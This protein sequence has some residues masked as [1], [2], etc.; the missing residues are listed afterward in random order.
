MLLSCTVASHIGCE[1]T[2]I[3]SQSAHTAGLVSGAHTSLA[4]IYMYPVSFLP[5]LLKYYI[6]F[7]FSPKPV[8]IETEKKESDSF[9]LSQYIAHNLGWRVLWFQATGI[10]RRHTESCW[11]AMF[12]YC[13]LYWKTWKRMVQANT[14]DQLLWAQAYCCMEHVP[15]DFLRVFQHWR[16]RSSITSL[17]CEVLSWC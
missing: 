10:T 11:A 8:S 4:T 17:L 14:T 15:E 5:S 16:G 13:S 12:W 7:Q 3:Y 1:H 6:L 9:V 2:A